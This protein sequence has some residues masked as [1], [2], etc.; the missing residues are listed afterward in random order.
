VITGDI[1][2]MLTSAGH[3]VALAELQRPGQY[4]KTL[5]AL[6]MITHDDVSKDVLKNAISDIRNS[7]WKIL[8]EKTMSP[9][10]RSGVTLWS[11]IRSSP[12]G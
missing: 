11:L 12:S 9:Q 10:S 6:K 2:N 1:K 4:L 8:P 3:E 5:S 7:F